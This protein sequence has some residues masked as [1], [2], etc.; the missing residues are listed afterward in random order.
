MRSFDWIQ[1]GDIGQSYSRDTEYCLAATIKAKY[2]NKV[3]SV[4][5]PDLFRWSDGA[6][7]AETKSPFTGWKDLDRQAIINGQSISYNKRDWQS[8][9][10]K[11]RDIGY[12]EPSGYRAFIDFFGSETLIKHPYEVGITSK[13]NWYTA[14]LEMNM[15]DP[16]WQDV[17]VD[18]MAAQLNQRKHLDGITVIVPKVQ[19]YDH[20][21]SLPTGKLPDGSPAGS[22][23][24][25]LNQWLQ[26]SQYNPDT[27]TPNFPSGSIWDFP[28]GCDGL[29]GVMEASSTIAA[30]LASKTDKTVMWMPFNLTVNTWTNPSYRQLLIQ[31]IQ[32]QKGLTPEQATEYM[33]QFIKK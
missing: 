23:I 27:N 21:A 17:W 19:W 30:K 3:F 16:K 31:D 24:A 2:G 28:G 18:Y 32:R 22:F 13:S 7:E 5:R 33:F 29:L 10:K 26:S 4:A 11:L 9:Y 20:M 1:M 12:T 14:F 6:I 8:D 25:I 15:C